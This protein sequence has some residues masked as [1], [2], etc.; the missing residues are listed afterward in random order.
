MLVS[1]ITLLVS[2]LIFLVEYEVAFL[3]F[4]H[5]LA[6]QLLF[7]FLGPFDHHLWEANAVTI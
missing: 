4:K 2:I 6:H 1:R 7:L 3:E 5:L